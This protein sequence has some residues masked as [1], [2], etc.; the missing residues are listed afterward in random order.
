M[1]NPGQEKR[2]FFRHPIHWP[3]ELELVDR[4]PSFTSSSHDISLGGLCF[5]WRNRLPKGKSISL[6]IPVREASFEV[7]AKVVYSKEDRKTGAYRTGVSFHDPSSA[8]RAKL[9]EEALKILEYRKTL[10]KESGR[11][12]SEEEAAEKWIKEYA[13]H[14][15]SP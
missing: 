15:A 14:F 3:I 10:S 11:E 8:L 5:Y 2:K 7:K 4:I 13:D 1:L 9:A 12:V 6:I